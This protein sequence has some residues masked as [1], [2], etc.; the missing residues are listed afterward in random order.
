MKQLHRIC[1]VISGLLVVWLMACTKPSYKSEFELPRQF[2]PGAVTIT[3]GETQARLQWSP[4]LFTAGKGVHYTVQ[5]AQDSAFQTTVVYETEV[6]TAQVVITD[7][8][9]QIN[10][11][12]FARI[13]ANAKGAT[14]SS[15]WVTSGRFRITGEQI[16]LP[17]AD[18]T[19]KDTSVVLGWRPTAG[20]TRITL[21]PAGGT[22]IDIVLTAADLNASQKL[23]RGL[24]PQTAYKAE[25]FKNTTVK[26]TISFTTKEKSIY[27]QVLNEGDDLVSAVA[28]ASNGDIIGLEK[29]VYDCKDANGAFVNLV[30]SQKHIT[31]QSLSGNPK[32]TRVNF[33]EL[34]VK[35]TGAGLTLKGIEFD[36]TAANADYFINFTGQASDAEAATFTS[37][38]IDNCI[39][40]K[41]NN[42]L[43][44]GNRGGNN[45]H[46]ID[47]IKINNSIAYNNGTGSYHY[48][49]LDKMEFKKIELTNSTFYDIARAFI[50]WATN[51]TVSPT[52]VILVDRCTLNSFGFGGSTRNNILLD[53]NAN[54]VDFT[55]QNS[56]IA[57]TPKP[58]ETV[59]TSL[60]KAG[61]AAPI[62]FQY[63]NYFN[64]TTGGAT[65]EPLTF[66][67]YVQLSNNQT[68][69]LGWR[70]TETSFTLPVGSPLRTAGSDGK[71]VG[72]PRWAQ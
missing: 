16:F 48:F 46:K 24:S 40:H 62:R 66:P 22:A 41:T 56:I 63:N 26:G 9:L 49:M 30:I 4:S 43:M 59:G 34:T 60:I 70:A 53:A 12:Y 35:G 71:A 21:S 45:A 25:I 65:P 47:F 2:M 10:Q 42:C 14:A 52:P 31:L 6:D 72:D 67:A 27:A 32:D 3:A 15:G 11:Y 1:F 23:I 33:K 36:G 39:V 19:L 5:L 13:K 50:S 38:T 51:I 57:N 68:I 55:M 17:V 54:S 37:I 61:T 69:D 44:R 18:A 58:N 28:A 8:V 64:L 29:G 7:S 20:L